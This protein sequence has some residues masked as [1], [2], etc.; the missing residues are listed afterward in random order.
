MMV[1][2]IVI[3]RTLH[4]ICCRSE[5]TR[6][7]WELEN[8]EDLATLGVPSLRKL[9][10]MTLQEL[11]SVSPFHFGIHAIVLLVL[12]VLPSLIRLFLS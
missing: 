1:E 7:E 8:H 9:S 10:C 6:G 4:R 2:G 5:G 12:L 3:E 11:Q